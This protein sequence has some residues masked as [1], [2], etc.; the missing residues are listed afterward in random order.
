V[1]AYGTGEYDRWTIE[2][3]G[4]WERREDEL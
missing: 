4:T 1:R 3:I 2:T